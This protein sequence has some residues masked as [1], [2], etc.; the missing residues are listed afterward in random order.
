[1]IFRLVLM[2][3]YNVEVRISRFEFMEPRNPRPRN[4]F[5][6]YTIHY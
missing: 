2:Y 6:L 5:V 1:M 4:W 3:A